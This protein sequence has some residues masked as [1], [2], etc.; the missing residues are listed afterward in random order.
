MPTRKRIGTAPLPAPEFEGFGPGLFR[1]FRALARHNERAWFEAHRSEYEDRVLTPLRALVDEMDARLGRL[2][3]EFTGGK[4]SIFRIHRDIRF[5]ADKRP[6]KTH[7]A[8]W[9]YHRDAGREGGLGTAVRASASL[10]LQLAPGESFAGGGLWTP[11]RDDLHLVREAIAERPEAWRRLLDAPAFRAATA[12]LDREEGTVLARVP[13]PYPA[14]HPAAEWLR[15]RSFTATVAFDDAEVLGPAFA[16]RLE[17]AYRAL[18]PLA[19]WLNAALGHR[20]AER[21]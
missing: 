11:E 18:L 9:F 10:Y 6:Y 21:R 5:S 8:A 12:G 4:R 20:S 2:A 17:G 3:P 13:R 19:R 14:D 16:D 7:A 15:F 1:F